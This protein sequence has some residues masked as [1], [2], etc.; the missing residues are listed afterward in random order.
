MTITLDDGMV[1]HV[2]PPKAIYLMDLAELADLEPGDG[3]DMPASTTVRMLT[4]VRALVDASLEAE[5][6]DALY[7]RLYDSNDGFDIN[8]LFTDVLP[9]LMDTVTKRP[10]GRPSASPRQRR[11]TSRRSTAP[12]RSLASTPASSAST[13]T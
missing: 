13:D 8:D 1:L 2:R 9:K 11:P 5:S 10:T 4:S 6:R 7:E 12:S 3:S